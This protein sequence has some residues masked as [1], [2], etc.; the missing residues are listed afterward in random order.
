MKCLHTSHIKSQVKNNYKKC[1]NNQQFIFFPCSLALPH[2]NEVGRVANSRGGITSFCFLQKTN[3]NHFGSSFSIKFCARCCL[4]QIRIPWYENT[5]QQVV[6]HGSRNVFQHCHYVC[7]RWNAAVTFNC[8]ISSC[9]CHVRPFNTIHCILQWNTIECRS[10]HKHSSSHLQHTGYALTW[11]IKK[12]RKYCAEDGPRLCF[13]SSFHYI[14]RRKTLFGYFLSSLNI[15]F[16]ANKWTISNGNIVYIWV[17]SEF[18]SA[19]IE[20]SNIAGGRRA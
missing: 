5:M 14:H 8:C 4:P 10:F 11:R 19:N 18:I 12:Q 16:C 13:H 3:R 2:G 7:W 20:T 1:E 17:I 6:Y 9:G 15:S